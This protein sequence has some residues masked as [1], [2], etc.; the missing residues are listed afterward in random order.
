T[1]KAQKMNLPRS[2]V[3]PKVPQNA[4]IRPV[5]SGRGC[6]RGLCRAVDPPDPSRAL[7]RQPAVLRDPSGNAA[8]LASAADPA[9]SPSGG[10][11]RDREP[12]SRARPRIQPEPGW[13]GVPR[14][15]PGA[16]RLGPAVDPRVVVRFDFRGVPA[17]RGPA[18]SWLVASRQEVDVCLKDP[19]Y[20]IDLVVA[21][22]LGAF[23]RVWL[24][25]VSFD[26]AVRSRAIR[27]E[28]PRDLVRA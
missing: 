17:G 18:T 2:R 26:H 15:H 23:T 6:L 24:G 16:G 4:R 7:R 19:G 22:D 1:P 5:L 20:G 21:A 27:L 28:G 3:R 13:G 10:R 8:D 11:R 12:T 9:P 25:D 14:R